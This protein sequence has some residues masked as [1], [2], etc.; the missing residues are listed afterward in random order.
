MMRPFR[1]ALVIA[2]MLVAAACGG[3]EPG[4]SPSPTNNA[5]DL[6]TT[7]TSPTS[8]GN[9]AGPNSIAVI[10]NSF[11]PPEPTVTVGSEVV[12]TNQG[13]APHSVNGEQAFD[14]H[15]DCDAA[16]F[17]KCMQPGQVFRHTFTTSGRFAY[18]CNIHGPLMSGAI[19]VE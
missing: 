9:P 2:L 6:P 14:S 11:D 12:W 7:T 15:P 13:A 3:D 19:V 17:D 5:T 10:D 16:N 4:A 8:T 18:S 1:V